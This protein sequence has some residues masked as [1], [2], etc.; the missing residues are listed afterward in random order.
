MAWTTYV[1][2]MTIKVET[3]CSNLREPFD[4]IPVCTESVLDCIFDE[5]PKSFDFCT[6]R[7]IEEQG[8]W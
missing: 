5:G 3:W 8:A 2:L 1:L 4:P 6:K 7:Y